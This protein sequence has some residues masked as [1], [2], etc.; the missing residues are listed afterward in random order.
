M[1]PANPAWRRNLSGRP[2]VLPGSFDGANSTSCSVRPALPSAQGDR[3]SGSAALFCGIGLPYPLV[4]AAIEYLLGDAVLEN[5]HRAAG[6]HP[7]TAAAL[8][9]FHQGVAA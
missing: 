1:R 8:A 2:A 5:L 4:E 7:A 6:D 3:E 9:V